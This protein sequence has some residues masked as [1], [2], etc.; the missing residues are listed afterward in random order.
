MSAVQSKLHLLQVEHKVASS[1]AD[2]APQVSAKL[3][4]FSIPLMWRQ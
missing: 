2:M 1:D 3:W 4:K